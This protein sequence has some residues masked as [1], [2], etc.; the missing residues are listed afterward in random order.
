MV[1][2]YQKL[3]VKTRRGDVIFG[4]EWPNGEVGIISSP[5]GVISL[6]AHEALKLKGIRSAK[7]YSSL[8]YIDSYFWPTAIMR[9]SMKP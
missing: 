4:V 3:Y 7:E 2:R 6:M 8:W 9:L 1:S 5:E